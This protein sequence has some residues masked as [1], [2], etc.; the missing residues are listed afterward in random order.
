MA[1]IGYL[2][3]TNPDVLSS[4][5]AEGHDTIPVG[6]GWDN[7]GKYIGHLTNQDEIAVVV[8]YLHKVVPP[9]SQRY[10]ATDVLNSCKINKIPVVVIAQEKE[11][12]KAKKALGNMADYVSLA[13]P[14]KLMEA[15]VKNL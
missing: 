15:I 2:E 6:N 4:L 5:I 1:I 3:G 9:R 11:H 13:D 14:T 7:H 8:G 12:P 10:E